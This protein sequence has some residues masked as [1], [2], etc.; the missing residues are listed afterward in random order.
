[1]L[2]SLNEF[3]QA[4]GQQLIAV[5]LLMLIDLVFG[6]VV[7]I[8]QGAFEASKIANFLLTNM[9]KI[10]FWL[11]VAY[12]EPVLQAVAPQFSS[13]LGYTSEGVFGV[14][15]LAF[16]GSLANHAAALG[17]KQLEKLPGVEA[18]KQG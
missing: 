18:T 1:M 14:L 2:P 8:R 10:V 11:A 13:A 15:A 12:I 4:V 9:P 16:L 17:I 3:A 6:V 7:A 5:V